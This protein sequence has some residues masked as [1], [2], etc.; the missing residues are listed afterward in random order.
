R[1][2]WPAPAF[3]I[4]TLGPW[5]STILSAGDRLL[6]ATNEGVYQRTGPSWDVVLP[7]A[8][9]AHLGVVRG[10]SST[11]I[12]VARDEV[13]WL[14]LDATGKIAA[15]RFPVPGLGSSYGSILQTEDAFWAELGTSQVARIVERE[16]GLQVR[17]L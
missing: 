13:A 6:L 8:V 15:Q 4:D 17:V 7:D 1:P 5:V 11:W 14:R 2:A 16:G 3:R 12:M 10:V 9:N